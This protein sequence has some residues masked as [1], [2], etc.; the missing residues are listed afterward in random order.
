ERQA[1]ACVATWKDGVYRGETIL[2]DDGH[3]FTDIW[4]RATVTKRGD[5][6]TVDLSDSHPQVSG[7]VNSSFP[8]TMSAVHMAF[9]YLIDPRTPKN[10]GTFRPVHVI[11][12]QGT[13]VWPFPPAPVTLSTNH[14]AQEIAEAIIRALAPACPERVMAGWGRRV[15]T[16]RQ[17]GGPATRH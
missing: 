7:F 10:S 11:V 17:G 5:A 9:A 3:E 14:C 6:L 15:C 2:D 1:R 4:I 13:I 8:N 16:A 12:R